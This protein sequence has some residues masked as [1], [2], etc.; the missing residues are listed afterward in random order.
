[1]FAEFFLIKF[2]VYSKDDCPI[3]T[4]IE[5]D[6]RSVKAPIFV[7]GMCLYFME[8]HGSSG[9]KSF[10][11][12]I[13]EQV[14]PGSVMPCVTDSAFNNFLNTFNDPSYCGKCS[15]DGFAIA[16]GYASKCSSQYEPDGTSRDANQCTSINKDG[17]WINRC[18]NYVSSL[19]MLHLEGEVVFSINK[20]VC[21]NRYTCSCE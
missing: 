13:C 7:N 17:E 11:E 10:G 4:R 15:Y 3:G 6:S 5:G 19:C 16:N 12:N 21:L 8:A 18:D 1:M 14:V 2:L 20:R 9:P